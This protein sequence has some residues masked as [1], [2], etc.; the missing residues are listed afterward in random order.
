MGMSCGEEGPMGEKA[1]DTLG[2]GLCS[3]DAGRAG[4]NMEFRTI[5]WGCHSGLV[6]IVVRLVSFPSLAVYTFPDRFWTQLV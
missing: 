4:K 1:K 6:D 3:E 5:F 2:Y